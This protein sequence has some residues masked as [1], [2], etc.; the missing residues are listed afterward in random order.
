MILTYLKNTYSELGV[1][2]ETCKMSYFCSFPDSGFRIQ[3][4]RIQVCINPLNLY[5]SSNEETFYIKIILLN[6]VKFLQ[7]HNYIDPQVTFIMKPV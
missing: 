3:R 2:F 5:Q 1:L 6:S 7:Y 4:F